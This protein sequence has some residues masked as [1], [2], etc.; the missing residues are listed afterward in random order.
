MTSMSIEPVREG[1]APR[2]S[3]SRPLRPGF[4]I[5]EGAYLV[6]LARS[7]EELDAAL[8]LRFGVFNL[9][10]DE[11]LASSLA[12]GRD[13]D[14][15]D[16]QCDHLLAIHEPSG[17]VVGTYRLQTAERAAEGHGFYSSDEFRLDQLGGDIVSGGVELGRACIALEHRKQRL[18]FALW[19]GL[20]TYVIAYGKHSLFGCCS[21][22]S[23][24]VSEGLAVM[25]WLR[26]NGHVTDTTLVDVMPGFECEGPAPD[27]RA[28]QAVSIP[29]LFGTYLRYGGRVHSRP[30]IDRRFKT[31]DFLVV[32]DIRQLDERARAMFL[33]GMGA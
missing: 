17:E 1:S 15:F 22:T 27:E 26:R 8:K 14:E 25:E 19:K 16:A 18:L 20:A 10:L 7:S 9:E 29:K 12:S 31:V 24:D 32:L 30:A 28:V 33:G 21:L 3:P 13:V 6:R 2:P 11:G 23:Q 5:R 4:E